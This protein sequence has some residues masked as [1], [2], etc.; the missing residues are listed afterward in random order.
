MRR[1]LVT[2]F[3]AGLLG[4]AAEGCRHVGGRCDCDHVDPC[5]TR[6]PWAGD[7]GHIFPASYNGLNGAEQL[8]I[9]PKTPE[10]IPERI[11]EKIPEK[12]N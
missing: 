7:F 8:K 6:A 9:A 3:A 10:K 1:L 2:L 11:P 12:N 5:Y 4:V